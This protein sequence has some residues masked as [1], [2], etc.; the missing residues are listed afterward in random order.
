MHHLCRC[1]LTSRLVLVL[2]FVSPLA[3][4]T[5]T[6][7]RY[8]PR[9]AAMRASQMIDSIARLDAWAVAARRVLVDTLT[10]GAFWV[11]YEPVVMT[12]AV[13]ASTP[14]AA[15]WSYL[16][17]YATKVFRIGSAETA[18]RLLRSRT[19]G[20]SS[21]APVSSRSQVPAPSSGICASPVG[22]VSSSGRSRSASPRASA[23]SPAARKWFVGVDAWRPRGQ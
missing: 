2:G 21:C 16:G 12:R 22:L 13:R 3:G 8:R 1:A 23:A 4:Q 9:D 17:G 6:A 18:L 20:S 7:P 10:A 19:D 15:V 14:E 11:E 5:P